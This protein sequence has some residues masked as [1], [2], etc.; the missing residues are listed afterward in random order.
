MLSDFHLIQHEQDQL[1]KHSDETSPWPFRYSFNRADAATLGCT[2]MSERI[3]VHACLVVFKRSAD[4]SSSHSFV[5]HNFYQSAQGQGASVPSKEDMS[6][7]LVESADTTV[8][9]DKEL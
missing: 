6:L 8:E 2:E 3:W 5:S 9:N 4:G 7:F 1:L